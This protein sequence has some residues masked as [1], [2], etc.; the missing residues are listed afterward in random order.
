MKVVA[1]TRK[2]LQSALN[3]EWRW[4]GLY[5]SGM[6]GA[7]VIRAINSR[8]FIL[9]S[10]ATV[11]FGPDSSGSATNVSLPDSPSNVQIMWK[12]FPNDKGPPGLSVP[13]LAIAMG[14]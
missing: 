6:G 4:K 13:S 7:G 11:I 5:D 9:T 1:I 2:E 10:L 14:L 3:S 8:S 12:G